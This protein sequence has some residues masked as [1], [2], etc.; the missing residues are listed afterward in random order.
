[1]SS[2]CQRKKAN[3][4][5]GMIKIN[6]K[7]KNKEII[8]SLYK[9]LVRP[10]LEYCVQAWCPYFNKDMEV[11]ERVQRRATRMIEGYWDI[12][13]EERLKL[14]GLQSLKNRHIQGDLIEAFK[15]I[16][17]IDKVDHRKFL[18]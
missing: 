3:S 10:N 15:I 13:Y 16:K 1:M 8:I 14:T 17:R 5:S 11:L 9:S 4:I 7:W 12:P 18:W 2:A 6:I